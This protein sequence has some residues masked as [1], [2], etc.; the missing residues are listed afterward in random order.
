MFGGLVASGGHIA[1]LTNRVL[2]DALWDWLALR[3]GCGLDDIWFEN[4]V[5]PD[6]TLSGISRVISLEDLD[7][8]RGSRDVVFDVET[9]VD[10]E[11]VFSM[12]IFSISHSES[13]TRSLCARRR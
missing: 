6:D 8:R 5:R 3:G 13:T 11:T 7:E 12:R 10:D 1:A 2:T 4:P 9:R